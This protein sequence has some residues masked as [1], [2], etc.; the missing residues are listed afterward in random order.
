MLIDE[1]I[2][3]WLS[4]RN[5]HVSRNQGK[6][7]P[8][9]ACAWFE[10]KRFH[11]PSVSFSFATFLSINLI[12]SFCTQFQLSALISSS[13]LKKCQVFALFGINWHALSQSAW[14]NF[15]MYIISHETNYICM[16]WTQVST[17]FL[18]HFV[19]VLCNKI[20]WEVEMCLGENFF[21]I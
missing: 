8:S 5:A 14:R 6:I 7:S 12:S 3:R 18:C 15:F 1:K 10:N 19:I 13:T 16:K 21:S 20:H 9:R 2:S 4:R 11:W 17:I